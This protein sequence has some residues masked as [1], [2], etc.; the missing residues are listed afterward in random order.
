[1]HIIFET[2]PFA[3]QRWADGYYSRIDSSSAEVAPFVSKSIRTEKSDANVSEPQPVVLEKQNNKRSACQT[4]EDVTNAQKKSR[5]SRTAG[6]FKCTVQADP[7]PREARMVQVR[8]I[9]PSGSLHD[10]QGAWDEEVC[11]DSSHSCCSI[12]RQEFESIWLEEKKC[13]RRCRVWYLGQIPPSQVPPTEIHRR[14]SQG[15]FPIQKSS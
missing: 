6:P 2:N 8:K 11:G 4:Q 14:Y 1:M 9:D 3:A 7:L 13:K 15:R 10:S 5:T 12:C